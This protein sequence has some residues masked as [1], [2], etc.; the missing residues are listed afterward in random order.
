MNTSSRMA[1]FTFNYCSATDITVVIVIMREGSYSSLSQLQWYHITM[2]I[3]ACLKNVFLYAL[4][5]DLPGGLNKKRLLALLKA[6]GEYPAKYRYSQKNSSK[7][8]MFRYHS[9]WKR[10][11][12]AS[13]N[14]NKGSPISFCP[15]KYSPLTSQD[16]CVAVPAAAP[17]EPFCLQQPGGEGGPSC[18]PESP[19]ALPHQKPEAAAGPAEVHSHFGHERSRHV[20]LHLKG[21]S[22]VYQ[23]IALWFHVAECR[24]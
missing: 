5:N 21:V 19:G 8:A 20:L 22:G 17:W 12:D 10:D 4:Q 2:L 15:L 16:V 1:D 7:D 13:C 14:Y 23:P 24:R 6:F 9:F 11:N 18:I 3:Y